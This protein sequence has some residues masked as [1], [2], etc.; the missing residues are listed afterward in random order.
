VVEG[1]LAALRRG[2]SGERYI[3]SGEN[4]SHLRFLQL[5][6]SVAGNRPQKVAL[7]TGLVQLLTGP[8][9]MLNGL[10]RLPL[11]PDMLRLAGMY[12]Y[13]DGLK[14]RVELGTPTPR[15]V[16]EA[17]AEALDWYRHQGWL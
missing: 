16:R 8:A 17:V 9:A 14:S 1:H 13:Y 4:L 5:I 3:L 15:P 2:R 11:H 7:P 12:F 6:S 10:V